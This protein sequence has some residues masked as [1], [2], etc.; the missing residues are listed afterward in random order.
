MYFRF[1]LSGIA[2]A[3]SAPSW[4]L[5]Y[6]HSADN[7]PIMQVRLGPPHKALPEVAALLGDLDADRLKLETA[8]M[9]AVEAAYNASLSKAAAEIP[10]LIDRLMSRFQ[11]VLKIAPDSNP[12]ASG[13]FLVPSATS[14]QEIR[15]HSDGPSFAARL[16]VLPPSVPDPALETPIREMEA[17]RANDESLIL[18]QAASEMDALTN[19]V[20]NELEAQ[21]VRAYSG[22]SLSQHAS[23]SSSL[24]KSSSFLKLHQ[25][26]ETGGLAPVT[27]VRVMAAEE[28]FPTVAGMVEDLARKR[29]KS[30]SSLRQRILELQSK[31][32]RAE[33]RLISDRLDKWMQSIVRNVN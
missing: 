5:A 31:L 10:E 30:E 26:V 1:V 27:N 19:I 21:I 25:P 11:R 7:L 6:S 16:S 3:S 29:D 23:V 33:N 13:R 28:P 20:K 15:S 32:L 18:K 4:P 8:Q 9:T 2:V 24:M 22:A 17:K 14:F 12:A